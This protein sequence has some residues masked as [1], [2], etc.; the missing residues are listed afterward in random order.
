[1]HFPCALTSLIAI[2]R[3]AGDIL[4]AY[5]H[6]PREIAIK[7]DNSPVTS[8]DIAAHLHITKALSTLTPD[9]P[10]I[11]EESSEAIHQQ[12]HYFKRFWL[13]DPLDGTKAFIAHQEDFAVNIALIE[14]KTPILGLIYAPISKTLYYTGED[15]KAYK[16][17]DKQQPQHIQAAYCN[18]NNPLTIIMNRSLPSDEMQTYLAPLPIERTLTMSSAIKFGIV[19]EGLAHLY[20]RFVHTMEWDTAAG[21]AIV[22]FAGGTVTCLDGSPLSYAKAQLENPHFIAKGRRF[23]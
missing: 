15:G 14:D 3:K 7:A 8:A 6:E 23:L 10:I 4:S 18:M 22:H 12:A 17:I 21:H 19:A 2:I 11:S 9:I 20:P 13:I 5:Y 16:L 1:M